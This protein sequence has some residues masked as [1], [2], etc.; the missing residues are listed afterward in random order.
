MCSP[1]DLV[2]RRPVTMGLV[3]S[4][5]VTVALWECWRSWTHL[6]E[7]VTSDKAIYDKKKTLKVN[8]AACA[9]PWA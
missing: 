5:L 7:R 1:L 2:V 3:G 9:Y 8:C 6:Q 4:R